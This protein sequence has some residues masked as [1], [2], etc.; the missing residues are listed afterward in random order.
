MVP[1]LGAAATAR[2][3]GA[4]VGGLTG[5]LAIGIP[6]FGVFAGTGLALGALLG[7]TIGAGTVVT[8][9]RAA[10]RGRMKSPIEGL[11]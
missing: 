8:V 9:R 2:L 5:A 11:M 10:S 7:G 1:G 4:T 6:S 3:V